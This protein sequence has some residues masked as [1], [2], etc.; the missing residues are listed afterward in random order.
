MHNYTNNSSSNKSETNIKDVFT[1]RKVLYQKQNEKDR[2]GMK[3][4]S[5]N[6]KKKIVTNKIVENPKGK[7]ILTE[8]STDELLDIVNEQDFKDLNMNKPKSNRTSKVSASSI[9]PKNVKITNITN[10]ILGPKSFDIKSQATDPMLRDMKALNLITQR[11]LSTQSKH[12]PID[13]IDDERRSFFNFQN[14]SSKKALFIDDNSDWP[15]GIGKEKDFC[16]PNTTRNEEKNDYSTHFNVSNNDLNKQKQIINI[17]NINNNY[18]IGSIN[19]P[20]TE[21]NNNSSNYYGNNFN[22]SFRTMNISNYKKNLSNVD[23]KIN[24]TIESVKSNNTNKTR[25]HIPRNSN[26][27]INDFIGGSSISGLNNHSIKNII[28]AV[29]KEYRKEKF[30]SLTKK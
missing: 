22:K 10:I 28:N 11:A 4:I 27:M 21:K 15:S 6:S 8:L 25:L 5:N 3:F 7:N 9:D 14:V 13:S 24:E 19:I 17:I 26:P 12:N 29:K 16:T 18:N 20:S 1:K 23:G 2:L 30:I